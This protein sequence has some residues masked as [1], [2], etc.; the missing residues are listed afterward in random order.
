MYTYNFDEKIE[1][2][3]TSCVK[4]DTLTAHF[5]TEDVIPMWVADMDFKTAPCVVDAV[6]ARAAHEILGYT[7][8]GDSYYEA[9]CDWQKRRHNWDITRP[10]IGFI[11]GVVAGMAYCIKAMTQP[12]DKILIQSPVY[13]P[14]HNL[15]KRN[16]RQLVYNSLLNENNRFEIDF[17]DLEQKLS[18]GCKMMLLCNP[19]N[20]GGRVWEKAELQ[21]VAALCARYG[22]L[23]ISDEIHA[24]LTLPENVHI[25]FACVSDEAADNCIT[26]SAPSK[27]FNMAGLGSSYFIIRNESIRRRFKTYLSASEL[28]N[29]HVFAF[30]TTEAAYRYGEGWL[31]QLLNY[32]AGNI[33][34][35][36]D[37]LTEH[38]PQVKMMVPQ[39]SFLIWLDFRNLHL[40]Q[41]ELVDIML[42]QAHVAM[43][44][45]ETF[46]VEGRGFMRLNIGTPRD[47]VLQALEQVKSAIGQI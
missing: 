31:S 21:K 41:K 46:G 36:Q 5:G 9:I 33:R 4:H 17:E 39:A 7:F 12:G 14:F 2:R 40:E 25:P 15:V 8:A 28:N 6:R 19:H 26:L 37:F 44:D 43:N 38:L 47:V 3:N 34:L 1:R 29:G 11:P 20:P 22:V 30:C 32:L 42:K 23:V 18:D 35:V 45:G 24:D 16:D 10:Q 13:T 27:A